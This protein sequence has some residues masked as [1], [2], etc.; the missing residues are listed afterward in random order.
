M[1]LRSLERGKVGL[2]S[3][4]KLRFFIGGGE[5]VPRAKFDLVFGVGFLS[6]GS[7][8]RH[9]QKHSYILQNVGMFL[10]VLYVPLRWIS[11][12]RTR[13]LRGIL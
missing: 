10:C 8:A 3:N 1:I 2:A 4:S 13:V 12:I 7:C 9:T 6:A 5:S 11:L